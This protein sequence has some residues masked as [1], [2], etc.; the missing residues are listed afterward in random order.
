MWETQLRS[1]IKGPVDNTWKVLTT[2]GL[3]KKV[4]PVHY[5]K[6]EYGSPTLVVDTKGKMAAESSQTFVFKV[7]EVDHKKHQTIT[8]SSI[9]FG[10]LKITKLLAAK[11]G[12]TE[13]KEDVVATGPF[14]KLFAKLF[15]EKQ[16]KATLPGQHEAIK[17]YIE[18]G[19]K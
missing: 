7:V 18:A 14:A 15:F 8:E 6:V 2:P 17:R 9:P 19:N 16:I 11:G 12:D 4:D 5:K 10:K 1:T 3:W 13:F